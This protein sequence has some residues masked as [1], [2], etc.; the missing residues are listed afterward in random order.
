MA[1]NGC[2]PLTPCMSCASGTDGGGGCI[3]TPGRTGRLR[4]RNFPSG[5]S[6]SD[7]KYANSNSP[8]CP[9]Y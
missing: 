6:P 4:D 5:N 9:A 1:A 8:T 2:F 3:V 7:G